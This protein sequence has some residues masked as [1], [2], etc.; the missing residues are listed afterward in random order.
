MAEEEACQGDPCHRGVLECA[1]GGQGQAEGL[2]DLGNDET[3]GIRGHGKHHEH[4]EGERSPL[5]TGFGASGAGF[6]FDL[7]V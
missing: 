1:R 5:E 6:R 4:D 7:Q 3:D 2:D